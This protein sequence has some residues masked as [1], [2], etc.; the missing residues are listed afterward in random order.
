MSSVDERA[1]G[2]DVGDNRRRD[3]APELV[4]VSVVGA[5]TQVDL[6]LPVV[7][8]LAALIADVVSHITSRTPYRADDDH[9][10]PDSEPPSAG[11][12]HWTLGFVGQ[13]ELSLQR[14]L[15][16]SGVRD[17]DLLELRSLA[18][19][20]APPLFDDVVDAIARL[21][22]NRFTSWT[23]VSARYAGYVVGLLAGLAGAVCLAASR[24]SGEGVAVAAM[25]GGAVVAAVVAATVLARHYRDAQTATV[26]VAAIAPIT[27]AT[28]IVLSPGDFGAAHLL[29]GCAL[30]FALA[31]VSYRLT[32]VGAATHYTIGAAALLGTVM[33]LCHL[34]M[35]SGSAAPAQN[36]A[37]ISAGV[38]LLAIAAAPRL[39]IV[40]A[41]LPLPPVPTAGAPIDSADIVPAPAIEGIGAIGATALPNA[42]ALERRSA[43]ASRYLTGIVLGAAAV[44]APAAVVAAASWTGFDT[45]RAVFAAVVAA[46]LCLRGRSHSD[47]LQAAGLI[48]AGASVAVALI[49]GLAIG[50]TPWPLIGF[51]AAIGLLV[52]ALLI[53][54]VAAGH[55]F[56]PVLRRTAEIAEYVLVLSVIPLL[57]WILDLYRVVREL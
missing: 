13:P 3:V 38:G 47:R 31:T 10:A 29:F 19:E 57:L 45:K 14:S 22:D 17:G 28:G 46:V 52:G 4:R 43:L 8:P 1:V 33:F 12:N 30:T 26:I 41:K 6:A 39:T 2:V 7:V 25:G 23:A 54:G 50:E 27:F 49:V 51:G 16:E 21:T 55:E 5:H 11:G 34:L 9:A 37:A 20:T 40:L 44:T 48:G 24:R 35:S 36:S 18:V 53:G 15:G 32:R 56:T 42:Q